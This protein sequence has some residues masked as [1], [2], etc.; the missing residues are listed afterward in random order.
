[1]FLYLFGPCTYPSRGANQRRYE[2]GNIH[3]RAYSPKKVS[4]RVREWKAGIFVNKKNTCLH[5]KHIKIE[6][7]TAET[8]AI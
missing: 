8:A 5:N 7:I 6:K 1:V 4:L 3:A 2:R